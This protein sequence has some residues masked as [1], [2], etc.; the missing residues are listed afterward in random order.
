MNKILNRIYNT[1]FSSDQE[2]TD[3]TIEYYEENPEELDLIIEEENFQSTFLLVFFAIGI[4]IT[5]F[6]RLLQ[7]IF[8]DW[9]P[10]ILKVVVLDV[11]SEVGIAVFGGTLVVYIIEF[12]RQKKYQSNRLFRDKI[13]EQL[14]TRKGRESA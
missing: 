12:L 13:N 7:F 5:V 1:T 9:L 14:K 2:I 3:E 10:E 4:S 8:G 11:M 6:S